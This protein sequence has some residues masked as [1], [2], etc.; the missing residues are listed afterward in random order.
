MNI[1]RINQTIFENLNQ[2]GACDGC[3]SFVYARRDHANLI[4]KDNCCNH[5][6]MYTFSRQN[7]YV[8]GFLSS[9]QWSFMLMIT[10]ESFF[11]THIFNEGDN[12]ATSKFTKYVEGM[13]ECFESEYTKQ[14]CA[15][16]LEVVSIG[17]EPVYNIS[18]QNRDG[19]KCF[20]KIRDN[21]PG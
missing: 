7:S 1:I 19:V 14:I 9:T 16:S 13:L 17:L 3:W 2:L 5:A 18:D 6:H 21:D 20:V 4:E 15:M 8:D 12:E 10:K 11:D